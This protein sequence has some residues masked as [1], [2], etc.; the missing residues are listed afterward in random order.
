MSA[1][2][3]GLAWAFLL[4]CLARPLPAGERELDERFLEGLRQRRLFE[5]AETHCRLKWD[6]PKLSAV[7]RGQLAVQWIQTLAE[8]A[9]HSLVERR[10]ALVKQAHDIA[11]DFGRRH[12]EASIRILV[13]SQESLADVIVGELARM[14]AEVESSPEKLDA[15]RK[16]SREAARGLEQLDQELTQLLPQVFRRPPGA[17]DLSAQQLAALQHQLR[18]SGARA[19]R[20]LGQ[21]YPVDSDDRLA[22]LQ[23]ALALLDKSLDQLPPDAPLVGPMRVEQATVLRLSGKLDLARQ[24]LAALPPE[25]V[26]PAIQL[27]ARAEAVRILLAAGRVAE[28]AQLAIKQREVAGATSAEFDFARLEALVARWQQAARDK[29]DT[30]AFQKDVEAALREIE[31]MHGAYWKHRGELLLVRASL[32][33]G[34]SAA[35]LDLLG[36]TADSLYVQGRIDDALAAYDQAAAKA[37]ADGQSEAAFGLGYKAALVQQR[38]EL[39]DDASRRLHDL[40]TNNRGL[41]QAAETHLLAAWNLA[42]SLRGAA[43]DEVRMRQST[44]YVDWLREHVKQWPEAA[45]AAQARLW[46][47]TWLANQSQWRDATEVLQGIPADSPHFA[48]ALPTVVVASRADLAERRRQGPLAL[49][50]AESYAVWFESLVF[51]RDGKLPSPWTERH[52]QAAIAAAAVRVDALNDVPGGSVAGST[53]PA[54]TNAAATSNA[55]PAAAART[56]LALAA[57]AESLVRAALDHAGSSEFVSPDERLVARRLLIRALAA[58][59]GRERDATQQIAALADDK[60]EVSATLWLELAEQL[61]RIPSDADEERAKQLATLALAALDRVDGR[62]LSAA[63]RGRVATLRAAALVAAGQ[64][65][66]ALQAYRELA[67]TQSKDGA[68]QEQYAVLLAASDN[69]ADR[70]LALQQWRKV[71]SRSEPRS[72]RWFRAKLAVATLQSQLGQTTEAAQLIRFLM[73]TPPGLDGTNLKPRFEELLKRCEANGGRA[74][75][76]P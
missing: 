76:A 11:A 69:R 55:D 48:A 51:D 44:Q 70:E 15:A 12:P 36:R 13:R 71:A 56:R 41:A 59:P 67:T 10:L 52:W 74:S 4:T 45:T 24:S 27:A 14:E 28:A 19:L 39:H 60:T 1:C 61:G 46:L 68:V 62:A 66:A 2:L 3:C 30:G 40:A 9:R 65:P 42:Q 18:L 6:Q 38:R 49:D 43:D 75:A 35:N 32:G 37:T 31:S 73:A 25:S 53:A 5:L 34:A 47:G 7:E 57:R 8:H 21:C 23:R 22:T 17:D 33:G 72:E 29:T 16:T 50:A 20:N 54:A 58:Q 63:D 26:T 64:R